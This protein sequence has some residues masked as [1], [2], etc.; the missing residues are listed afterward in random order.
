MR[1]V[2]LFATLTY[3]ALAIE[4]SVPYWIQTRILIPNLIV[5]LAVD[6]GLRNHGVVP[7]ILAFA[8]G[9]ATDAFSGST[10]GVNAFLITMVFLLTYEISSRLLVT[11]A[12]VGA[13]FVFLGVIVTS[14]GGLVLAD[15]AAGIAATGAML[16]GIAMQ[17][18]ISAIVAPLVFGLIALL[19]RAAGLPVA[20]ARE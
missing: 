4:T 13:T 14:I 9:Y 10:L 12:A 1:L 5:I 18:A 20:L 11:N 16:P 7:A 3:L 8:M 6:L 19:K 2:I 15:G 17:A